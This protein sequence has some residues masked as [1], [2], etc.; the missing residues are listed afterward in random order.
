M[1]LASVLTPNNNLVIPELKLLEL[2][3][4]TPARHQA[5]A[6]GHAVPSQLQNLFQDK[7]NLQKISDAA[8]ALVP[9]RIVHDK[10]IGFGRKIFI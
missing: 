5:A 3:Q 7:K 4:L 9:H 10:I 1:A 8:A 6:V 2:A